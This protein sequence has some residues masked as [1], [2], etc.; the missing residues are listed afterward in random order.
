[1]IF[2]QTA[3]PSYAEIRSGIVREFTADGT[4][5]LSVPGLIGDPHSVRV[6][7]TEIP[8]RVAASFQNNKL[9]GQTVETDLPV[10]MVTTDARNT[11]V[12]LRAVF[13][14]DG[15]WQKGAKVFVW[16]DWAEEVKAE[17]VKADAAP[18]KSK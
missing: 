10:L 14:N 2:H 5:S 4:A 3:E 11:P 18:A 9:N 16:G 15:I 12:L 7:S 1:M 17:E 13:S 8:L 6:G